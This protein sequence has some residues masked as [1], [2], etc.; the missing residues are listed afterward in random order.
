MYS[1][2]G[3]NIT[4]KLSDKVPRW[5]K[6][7]LR[8]IDQ[9]GRIILAGLEESIIRKGSRPR[10]S[11]II[12]IGPP[13]S[14]TTLVYQVFTRGLSLSYFCNLAADFHLSPGIVTVVLSHFTKIAPSAEFISNYGDTIGWNAPSQGRGIWSRW[15]PHDQSYVRA[16]QLSPIQLVETQGTVALVERAFGM[17]FI[18]KSQ[19]HCVR[20]L[21]LAEAFPNIL[22]VKVHRNRLQTAQSILYGQKEVFGNSTD[23][24]SVRPKNYNNIRHHDP[25]KRVCEQ[26]YCLEE[27]MNSDIGEVGNDRVFEVNYEGFC[28]NPKKTLKA[29][30]EFYRTRTGIHLHKRAEVPSFFSPSNKMKVSKKE[31]N[32]L[33]RHAINLWPEQFR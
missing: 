33:K 22:F 27:D 1:A 24:F 8:P 4:E 26:I 12:I 14:G 7:F 17:P 30:V 28:C 16:G 29:F 10:W 13:R 6:V 19:G 15:F 25:I 20:M 18:N 21:P 32:A 23:W 2:F 11:P 5:A 31:Y 9:K 3:Y